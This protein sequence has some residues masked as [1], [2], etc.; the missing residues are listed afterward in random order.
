MTFLLCFLF[1]SVGLLIGWV[2]SEKYTAFMNH[3]E[4]D[5]EDLFKEN[6]HPEIF[7]KD[8]KVNRGDYIS[9]Q[10]E[11]GYDPEEWDPSDLHGG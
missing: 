7:N 11:T 8:G 10:F 4:H 2:A 5:F 9:I 3:I 6:P 1:M